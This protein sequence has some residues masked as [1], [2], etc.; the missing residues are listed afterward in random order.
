MSPFED[1]FLF[2]VSSFIVGE[3]IIV[4][5][6]GLK[7][8]KYND[9]KCINPPSR[10]MCQVYVNTHPFISYIEGFRT[11]YTLFV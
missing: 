3:D 6:L 1:R 10:R 7:D 2:F 8:S 5:N 11:N 4:K 9:M